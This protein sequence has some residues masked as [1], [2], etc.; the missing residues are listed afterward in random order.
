MVCSVENGISYST[1]RKY[2]IRSK[3][4]PSL[5]PAEVELGVPNYKEILWRDASVFSVAKYGTDN[6]LY[7]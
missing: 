2:L 4:F 5:G 7:H 1:D 6:N 3:S